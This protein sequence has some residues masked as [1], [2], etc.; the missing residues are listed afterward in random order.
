MLFINE[1]PLFRIEPL[2]EIT[3]PLT[4]PSYTN[5]DIGVDNLFDISMIELLVLWDYIQETINQS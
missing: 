5:T 4:N 1:N 3:C 2:V